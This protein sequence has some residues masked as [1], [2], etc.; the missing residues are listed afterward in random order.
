MMMA[1][2]NSRRRRRRR[3]IGAVLAAAVVSLG[4]SQSVS[5]DPSVGE[6]R[7]IL[8]DIDHTYTTVA[9]E[10]DALAAVTNPANLGYLRGFNTVK[11]LTLQTPQSLRR[12]SGGSTFFAFPLR[13]KPLRQG[14]EPLFTI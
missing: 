2:R 14:K 9:G 12:G 5:A 13:F 6:A 7:S 1:R 11:E 3:C 4:G 10:A 8:R